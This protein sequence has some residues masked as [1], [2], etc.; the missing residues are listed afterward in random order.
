MQK[1]EFW[2]KYRTIHLICCCWKFG[3]V[4]EADFGTRNPW[5]R[6]GIRIVRIRLADWIANMYILL[7]VH[8][9]NQPKE[10]QNRPNPKIW[11]L[12]TL[13]FS[14]CNFHV[15][16]GIFLEFGRAFQN[17]CSQFCLSY[18]GVHVLIV[19]VVVQVVYAVGVVH[20][21]SL[22]HGVKHW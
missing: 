22:W 18:T 17:S 16:K 13:P 2:E 20:V 21:V 6:V 15:K 4:S 14:S 9:I 10:P 3:T 7:V 5:L 12:F 11:M 8:T 19:I 1:N